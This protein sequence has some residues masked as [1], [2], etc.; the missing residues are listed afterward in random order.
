MHR[1]DSAT[2]EADLFGAG[3]DGFTA[4]T[5]P[6]VPPTD[7]TAKFFNALQQELALII[8]GAGITLDD[9]D[10]NQLADAIVTLNSNKAATITATGGNA[11]GLT[12]T[13]NGSG[14]G[15][16]GIGGT[17]GIGVLGASSSTY[18]VKGTSTATDGSAVYGI[19]NTGTSAKGVHGVS[20][21]GT[22]G[23]GTY[24]EADASSGY[25]A[26]GI[27]W[28]GVAGQS[29][30]ANGVGVEGSTTH[31]TGVGVRG[32][33]GA[34]GAIGVEARATGYA[35]TALKIVGNNTIAPITVTPTTEPTGAAVVGDMYMDS[36]GV[37]WVCTTP[38]ANSGV[39][40]F[41]KVSST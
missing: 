5:P 25:G 26:I 33:V 19:A 14:A 8:E 2:A 16:S 24:G 7:L 27:G 32:S 39:H 9:S 29:S 37:L 1:I 3:K 34:A 21:A 36:A 41:V 11:V 13:G 30:G 22:G 35:A 23:Y 28:V 12:A 17:T 38:G 18:G 10:H 40:V 20:T 15:L 6:S 4:G 31:A